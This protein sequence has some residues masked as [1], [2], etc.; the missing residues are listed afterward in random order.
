MF[1]LYSELELEQAEKIALREQVEGLK[2]KLSEAESLD[3]QVAR[4][5]KKLQDERKKTEKT[6]A[7][8]D[9]TRKHAI[10][11]RDENVRLNELIQR[12]QRGLETKE[13]EIQRAQNEVIE[14]EKKV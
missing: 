4:L 13:E 9:E 14:K 1:P 8:A 3:K 11:E 10:R 5:Q 2:H 6:T 12:Q 7:L